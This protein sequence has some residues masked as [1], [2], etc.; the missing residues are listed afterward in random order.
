MHSSRDL[1]SVPVSGSRNCGT[2]RA[3][4]MLIVL[5]GLRRDMR[6]LASIAQAADAIGHGRFDVW[7]PPPIGDEVGM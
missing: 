6:R 7:L 4:A 1:S 3:G 5:G 2:R